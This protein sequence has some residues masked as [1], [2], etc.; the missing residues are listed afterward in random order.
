MKDKLL[1]NLLLITA[2]LSAYNILVYLILFWQG[3][4]DYSSFS[5]LSLIPQGIFTITVVILERKYAN[6][7]VR[8]RELIFIIVI[9]GLTYF[10]NLLAWVS[11][12]TNSSDYWSLS[13]AFSSAFGI[14]TFTE[15]T[16]WGALFH[17]LQIDSQGSQIWVFDG[18]IGISWLLFN[19]MSLAVIFLMA[20]SRLTLNSAPETYSDDRNL[21]VMDYSKCNCPI[22]H[23]ND[24]VCTICGKRTLKVAKE[25][26]DA[27][28]YSSTDTESEI[29][30]QKCK[31]SVKQGLRFCPNCGEATSKVAEDS[32]EPEMV[33]DQCGS[34][35]AK[36]QK[37]CGNCGVEIVWS[38][39]DN[40][41]QL[42][43]APSQSQS[44]KTWIIAAVVVGSLILIGLFSSGGTNQQE[45]C[46]KQEMKK[47]GAFA[48]P[49]GWA[50]K[51]RMYCQS[52]YP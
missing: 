11:Y 15:G 20:V 4:P 43:V 39:F 46:F 38:D 5:F 28:V 50:I 24:G 17:S 22:T 52:L 41:Q 30:C 18:G 44:K 2:A 8:W 10:M 21:S 9:W 45:E 25:D 31:I 35:L 37:F 19:M 1:S 7:K 49:K 42:V 33:C 6:Q 29:E 14:P 32:K 34:D 13:T 40:Q 51:S 16:P 36:N 27:S 48:D 47:F 23:P 3:S 12:N 26:R